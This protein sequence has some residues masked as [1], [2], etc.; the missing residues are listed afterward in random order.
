MFDDRDPAM[1]APQ[2]EENDQPVLLASIRDGL[3]A[4]MVE[5]LLHE[6]GIPVLRKYPET[7]QVLHLIMGT[8]L[9]GTEL[10]VPADRFDEAYAL[11]EGIG[12]FAAVDVPEG[13]GEAEPEEW[14]KGSDETD[15]AASLGDPAGTDD[16]GD[17]QDAD[18]EEP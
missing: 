2:S 6:H 15:D 16:P 12:L 17:A 1:G 5:S 3:E 4:G 13:V 11:L 7:G 9:Y 18:G 14:R 10:Y 8:S